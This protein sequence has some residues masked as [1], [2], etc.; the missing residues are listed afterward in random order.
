M[1]QLSEDT[2]D[3]MAQLNDPQFSLSHDSERRN[4]GRWLGGRALS[5]FDGTQD[6]TEGN[7]LYK[8]KLVHNQRKFSM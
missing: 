5:F 8:N 2:I 6:E 7:I 1:I 3:H 4:T